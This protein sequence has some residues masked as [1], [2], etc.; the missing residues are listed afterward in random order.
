MTC[1]LGLVYIYIYGQVNN[2]FWLVNGPV[3]RILGLSFPSCF[4]LHVVGSFFVLQFE[5]YH[6]IENNVR[7]YTLT[8][9]E[10]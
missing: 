10:S 3:L 2:K 4:S 9:H 1:G 7:L 6:E 8:F 5:C